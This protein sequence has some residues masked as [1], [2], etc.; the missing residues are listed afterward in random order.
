MRFDS[1]VILS[2][3][4]STQAIYALQFSENPTYTTL[5]TVYHSSSSVPSGAIILTEGSDAENDEELLAELM[6]TPDADGR[7]PIGFKYLLNEDEE[8]DPIAVIPIFDDDNDNSGS[9]KILK[10]REVN[11]DAWRWHTW[12]RNQAIYKRDADAEAD[13]NA[14][15]AASPGADA[16]RW[17]T[18][19]R[20]QAIYKREA[21]AYNSRFLAWYLRNRY[22][23]RL[24]S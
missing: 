12:F 3:L 23:T 7:T 8:A 13:A 6:N 11:A 21:D 5:S 19:F 20:N 22:K 9:N 15:A 17:H 4:A 14:F 24:Y 2:L 18:W 1:A 16:W 10:N